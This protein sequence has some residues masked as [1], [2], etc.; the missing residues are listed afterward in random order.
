MR[1]G[2]RADPDGAWGYG[3]T[4]RLG[5]TRMRRETMTTGWDV[6]FRAW[7]DSIDDELEARGAEPATQ[8]EAIALWNE[9]DVA[10]S[11]E[12]AAERIIEDRA[13]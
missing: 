3:L 7:W 13:R 10:H 12:G 8:A 9:Y 11:P 1:R 6:R 5:Q 4:L 2:G